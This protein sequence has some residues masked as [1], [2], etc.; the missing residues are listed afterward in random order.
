MKRYLIFAG[1]DTGESGGWRSFREDHNHL[2]LT[3]R[4]VLGYYMKLVG[5]E[6]CHIVDTETMEIVKEYN[7]SEVFDTGEE[8]VREQCGECKGTGKCQCCHGSGEVKHECRG[9]TLDVIAREPKPYLSSTRYSYY[10]CRVCGIYWRL[11]YQH[12]PGS[13]DSSSWL[14]L[15]ETYEHHSFTQEELDKVLERGL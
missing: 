9:A 8:L 15:G 6:W 12:D 7:R 10:K 2:G 14:R 3:K 13:G 5:C 4:Q 11:R 1:S